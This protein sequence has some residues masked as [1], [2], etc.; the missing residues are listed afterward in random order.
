MKCN[1]DGSGYKLNG[2][3]GDIQRCSCNAPIFEYSILFS[4][5]YEP[6]ETQEERR[7]DLGSAIAHS[8]HSALELETH[9]NNR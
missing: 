3:T 7:A 4:A 2:K 1:C 5:Q 9:M 8:L 6:Y